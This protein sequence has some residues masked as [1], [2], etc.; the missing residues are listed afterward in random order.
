MA[1][2]AGSDH[3][4]IEISPDE[5]LGWVTEAVQCMDLPSI[6]AINTY[7][8]SKAV[9]QHG[10]KVALSGLGGDELFGGYPSFRDAP[11]L[12]WLGIVP[13]PLRYPLFRTIGR[14]MG[15][16]FSDV[17]TCSSYDWAVARRRFMGNRE[18]AK[19]G[20]E[21]GLSSKDPQIDVS[22]KRS[23]HDR[24]S[25]ISWAEL[26]HYMGPMLLRDSDQMSMAVSLELRVPFLDHELVDYVTGLPQK[27]KKG[28]G[29]KPLLVKAFNDILPREVYA[30]KKQ[31]FALPMDHWMRGPL[32]GFC[33]EGLNSLEGIVN[34]EF[35]ASIYKRFQQHAL[36]W[37]RLW[38]LVV[39][40]HYLNRL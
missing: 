25:A 27:L 10:I 21:S 7:V 29:T 16:K 31:G 18:L 4:E 40:G 35:R 12:S 36:H 33:E 3:T 37:T 30:R 6:D 24:F 17:S 38:H 8:V 28:S 39:L 1:Q 26:D 5:C 34:A 9:S 2:N 22:E 13:K 14:G 20:L 32:A 23:F 11:F 15:E 19:A